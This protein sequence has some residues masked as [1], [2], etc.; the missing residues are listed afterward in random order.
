VEVIRDMLLP[1]RV[2][3]ETDD[4]IVLEIGKHDGA[5][6]HVAPP[7]GVAAEP[8]QFYTVLFVTIEGQKLRVWKPWD[9]R[10]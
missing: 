4:H 2:L 1:G 6:F 3:Q 8:Q 7:E 10:D 9:E 5:T